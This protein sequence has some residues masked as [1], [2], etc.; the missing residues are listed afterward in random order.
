MLLKDKGRWHNFSTI[1]RIAVF[2]LW[3]KFT[4]AEYPSKVMCLI[5]LVSFFF[6][7]MF[8]I[9][10][11]YWKL[12]KLCS[13]IEKEFGLLGLYVVVKEIISSFLVIFCCCKTSRS[14]SLA[15][16]MLASVRDF[17]YFCYSNDFFFSFLM[18][19][20]FTFSFSTIVHERRETVYV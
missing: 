12:L 7:K 6:W 17:G 20:Y 2:V 5:E 10:I 16:N 3:F 19:F 13:I 4:S 15:F 14:I 11:E 8:D 1:F 18:S 9:V